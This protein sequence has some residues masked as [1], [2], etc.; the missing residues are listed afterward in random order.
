MGRPVGNF[1]SPVQP[2]RVT[3]SGEED[4][5][6]LALRIVVAANLDEAKAIAEEFHRSG[7]IAN[8]HHGVEELDTHVGSPW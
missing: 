6:V 2:E 1:P 8:A 7:Q 5:R 3:S 4:Q